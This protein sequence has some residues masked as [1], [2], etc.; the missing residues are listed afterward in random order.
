MSTHNYNVGNIKNTLGLRD[1][2]QFSVYVYSVIS[3]MI[4]RCVLMSFFVRGLQLTDDHRSGLNANHCSRPHEFTTDV[5]RSC[6]VELKAEV[7]PMHEVQ[8][9]LVLLLKSE[10]GWPVRWFMWAAFCK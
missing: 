6:S 5:S 10:L 4:T 2:F 3:K 9:R 1:C 8:G 7:V